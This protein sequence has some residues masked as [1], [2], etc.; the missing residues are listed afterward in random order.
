MN[1][2]RRPLEVSLLAWLFIF[3]AAVSLL[4]ELWAWSDPELREF[5]MSV[6]FGRRDDA[7]ME[8]PAY[9]WMASGLVEAVVVLLAAVGLL[10]ARNWARW[11]F[12]G[13]QAATTVLWWIVTGFPPLIVIA[14]I[15]IYLV[16]L[17]ILLNPRSRTYFAGPGTR[18]FAR[19]ENQNTHDFPG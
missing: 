16:F 7:I 18:E 4:L 6:G 9:V 3:I 17:L 11:L 13:I 10:F 5:M 19:K 15:L 8:L 12:L 1:N 14:S 2:S